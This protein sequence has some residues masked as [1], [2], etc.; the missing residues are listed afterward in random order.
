MTSNMKV[1][2]GNSNRS[3]AQAICDNM[4]IKLAQALVDVFPGRETKVEI[5]ES[6]R[7]EDVFLIQ[8][9]CATSRLSPAGA[10][11]R[12]FR[13]RRSC[14]PGSRSESRHERHSGHRSR[15]R[16]PGSGAQRRPSGAT[17]RRDRVVFSIW[18]K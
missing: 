7:G 5:Q 14:I 6:V 8:P 15:I 2:T 10:R 18:M 11:A 3:L 17:A 16:P 9:I 1:F 12:T 4:D 13:S